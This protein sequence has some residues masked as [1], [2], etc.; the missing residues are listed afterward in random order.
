MLRSSAGIVI[1]FVVSQINL[2]TVITGTFPL[3]RKTFCFM[4]SQRKDE[5]FS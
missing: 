4:D 2:F 5:M 3:K 1:V